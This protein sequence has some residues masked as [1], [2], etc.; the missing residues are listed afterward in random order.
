MNEGSEDELPPELRALL[1]RTREAPRPLPPE[2]DLRAQQR[3]SPYFQ[4]GGPGGGASGPP[5][6]G[7]VVAGKG[8]LV[9][10]GAT[11]GLL[12]LWGLSPAPS[13]SPRPAPTSSG[14]A[15][16]VFP[17]AIEISDPGS[18]VTLPVEA[19]PSQSAS[20]PPP[21]PQVPAASPAPQETRPGELELLQGARAA[22]GRKDA[23]AAAQWL[24]EHQRLYPAGLLKEEREALRVR[25]LVLQGKEQEASRAREEFLQ[26]HPGSI[27]GETVRQHP[28]GAGSARE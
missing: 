26:Q 8:W 9:L 11:A 27:L 12:A 24:Q 19:L 16:Q 25:L 7:G 6:A 28:S 13:A 4:P 20:A 21:R 5:A 3:L 15:S 22:L 17:A 23:D 14:A 10:A 2:V 1:K 18:Q